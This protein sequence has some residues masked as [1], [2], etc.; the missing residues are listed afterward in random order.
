MSDKPAKNQSG[1]RPAPDA[2][3]QAGGRSAS[4]GVKRPS[5]TARGAAGKPERPGFVGEKI[6]VTYDQK[7]GWK[8]P[9]S[10]VLR[11]REYIIARILST[12]EDHGFGAAR[13]G[14]PRWWERHHR[15]YY[16]AETVDGEVFE[17]YW[18]RGSKKKEWTAVRRIRGASHPAEEAEEAAQ[19]EE[20]A[21]QEPA[22]EA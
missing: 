2:K 13:P 6:S 16:E 20:K 3:K 12:R 4:E 14:R 7:V 5:A 21:A 9:K 11:E 15:V 8:E 17:L 10:F 19:A 1:G 18:D 22:P